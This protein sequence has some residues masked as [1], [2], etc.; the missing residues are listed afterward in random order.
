[1]T[2]LKDGDDGWDSVALWLDEILEGLTVLDCD[3]E[4]EQMV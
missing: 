2:L 3:E 1:M 4:N